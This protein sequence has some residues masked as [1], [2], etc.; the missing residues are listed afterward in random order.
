MADARTNLAD[1]DRKSME[2]FFAG[3]GEKPFR[4][5]QVIQW[6]HQQ[7]VIE[8]RHMTNLGKSLRES[9]IETARVDFPEVVTAQQS[10]DGTRKWLLRV[11]AQ[12]CIETVF[13]PERDRGTLC[14]SSQ[15]GCAMKCSFCATGHQGF[16]R[17]LSVS[18][19]IG[20]VWT[21]N[22]ILGHF[23][24]RHRIITNIVMMGMGE[25]LL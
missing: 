2:D 19:I 8:F 14:V 16:S 12:N 11:D 24:G 18:E 6:I 13:I 22:K 17:N 23:S 3:I 4:A 5:S 21:A 1:M 9:L 7:G 25:P 15:A 20:Q 10:R